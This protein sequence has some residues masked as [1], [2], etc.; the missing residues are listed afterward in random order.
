M[1]TQESVPAHE[2]NRELV[3]GWLSAWTPRVEQAAKAMA[4]IYEV[5]PLQVA[6][7]EDVFDGAQRAQSAVIGE[8]GL[9]SPV[10]A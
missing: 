1:V 7:F 8:L 5:P 3:Q 2:E 10:T 6:R 9:T 4:E